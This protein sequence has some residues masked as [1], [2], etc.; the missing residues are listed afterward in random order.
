[1]SQGAITAN[2]DVAQV[3][4]YVFWLFFFLLILYLRREDK[5]EGYPLQ[6][7]EPNRRPFE[8]VPSMPKP[9]TFL[10]ADGRTIQAPRDNGDE[11]EPFAYRPRE[12]PG[13]PLIPAENPM[14]SGV[15][16][17]S[18]AQR[19]DHPD[20]TM[21]GHPR[22][23]PLRKVNH[24]FGLHTRDPDPR[25]MV[26]IGADGRSAG[27]VSDV[28]VDCSEMIIRYLEVELAVTDAHQH[29]LLPFNMTK[30]RGNARRI[31]VCAILSHQFADVPI[32]ASPDQVTLY[33]EDMIMGYYGGG[34]SF[35][36]HPD[37]GPVQ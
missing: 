8:G 1:M 19:D 23:Q 13:A 30:V 31:D 36:R 15:G 21:E 6:S 37:A 20:V 35:A 28:W 9:K 25:G 33:E 18:Y 7:D 11:R 22:I 16:S 32:T 5:R 29:V 2:L 17:G 24:E 14:L 34:Y 27:T 26:V 4:L 10:L 3:V 12:L